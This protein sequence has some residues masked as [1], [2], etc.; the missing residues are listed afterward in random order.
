MKLQ[1]IQKSGFTCLKPRDGRSEILI[2]ARERFLGKFS[3]KVI[4]VKLKHYLKNNQYRFEQ[5]SY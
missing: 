3:M 4:F 1:E 5:N 2:K